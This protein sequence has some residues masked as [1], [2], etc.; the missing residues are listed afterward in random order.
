MRVIELV[1]R[2]TSSPSYDDFSPEYSLSWELINAADSSLTQGSY[3]VGHQTCMFFKTKYS[4][5]VMEGVARAL[6]AQKRAKARKLQAREPLPTTSQVQISLHLQAVYI[7]CLHNLVK[8]RFAVSCLQR[9]RRVK[10]RVC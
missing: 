1:K 4:I 3:S 8:R 5:D 10:V 6:L 9:V 2:A 7:P